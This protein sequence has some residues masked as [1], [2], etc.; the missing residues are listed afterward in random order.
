[1]KVVFLDFDGP[2]IPIQSHQNKRG[3][4]EKAWPPCIAA[5][6]RITDSTGAKIVISRSW[7]WGSD[8]SN[9][10][11][12]LK[13]WGVTG[14]IIGI[15]PI[16]ETAWKPDNK[17]WI[18]VPRGREIASWLSDNKECDSFVILD[19]DDDMEDLKPRLIQTP[20]EIGLTEQDADRAIEMLNAVAG[21]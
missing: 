13:Q 9:A 12:L 10:K 17:L 16:L 21:A 7:R 19:D 8:G 20:F 4:R 5:L 1:M 18:A 14:E 2:I 6:N 15:T 3:L 11:M